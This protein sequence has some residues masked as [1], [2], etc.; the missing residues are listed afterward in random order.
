MTLLE[1]RNLSVSFGDQQILSEVNLKVENQ[2]LIAI[3][4]SSG[5]GKSTLLRLIAQKVL[6]KQP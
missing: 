2:E 6:L 1:I 4:G 5:A 3:L